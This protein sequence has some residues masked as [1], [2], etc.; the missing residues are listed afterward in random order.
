MN[1]HLLN[2]FTLLL[3]LVFTACYTTTST[4]STVTES[5]EQAEDLTY[6]EHELDPFSSI[7]IMGN[8]KTTIQPSDRSH[9]MFKGDEDDIKNVLVS[10]EDERLY[11]DRK[12]SAWP[13][14]RAPRIE[15]VIETATDLTELNLSGSNETHLRK[16]GKLKNLRLSG[17]TSVM[18]DELDT[19]S[20]SIRGS[21]SARVEG[22]GFAD[23]L[24]IRTSGASRIDFEHTRS[25]KASIRSSGSSRVIV[26]VD[27][28]L[29][30][31]SSGASRVLYGGSPDRIETSTSGSSS[32]RPLD[33]ISRQ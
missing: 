6:P 30:V 11:V 13:F 7:R 18:L 28:T 1:S 16:A 23:E 12:P 17:S 32:I 2:T 21:W 8:F 19:D 29:D 3:A 31:R 14:R 22:N 4:H 9:I 26:H 15:M 33:Q 27:E 24:D 10:V 20:L 25:I 5:I